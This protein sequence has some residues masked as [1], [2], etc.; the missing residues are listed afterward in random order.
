MQASTTVQTPL[1]PPV[2]YTVFT[3]QQK[4]FLVLLLSIANLASPLTATVYLPLFPLL[5]AHFRVSLQA[6]NLTV[7]LYIVFQA[8][9]PI[10]FAPAS[11]TLGRRPIIL[12]TFSL[13]TLASLGLVLNRHSYAGL[14]TIRA[15]QSL[16]ASTVQAVSYGII[17]DVC[18]PAERGKMQGPII[19]M[20]NLGVNLGPLLGGL[21]AFKSGDFK[22]AFWG[23]VA[24]GGSSLLV[25]GTFLKE[26]A[27]NVV[28]NGDQCPKGWGA[29]TWW[30]MITLKSKSPARRAPI[31]REKA[32]QDHSMR[33]P[34]E[35]PDYAKSWKRTI[36]KIQVGSPFRIVFYKDTAL[37]LW[38]AASA[39][40]N[41]Y[42]IQ[43]SNAPIYKDIYQFN[44][45]EIGL[46]Y[47]PGG[48]GVVLGAY[49]NGKLMDRNYAL[50]AKEIGHEIDHVTGDDLDIFPIERARVRSCWIL[51]GI[52]S[53]GWI[54]Y[55]WALEKSVHASV[56]LLLQLMHGFLCTCIL[57]TFNA[58]LVDVF[59]TKPS[60]AATS[61]NI[62]RCALSALYVALL[63]PLVK[64]IGRGW[65]FTVLGITS[66]LAGGLAI[67]LLRTKGHQW[68]K[69][70]GNLLSTSTVQDTPS[71]DTG[72][73]AT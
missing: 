46:A 7:T 12:T 37:T 57:Q 64:A 17:A 49:A 36:G 59:P 31:L 45:L 20:S 13:Y 15:L 24:F 55:G 19:S 27:R 42:C 22:W 10:L 54:G 14:I 33:G 4:R 38:M 66:G 60:A 67:F 53:C 52:S 39:Y 47:L 2:Q 25:L 32:N 69:Q 29:R 18:V 8:I 26:T 72:S 62:T 56:P 41:Y 16:G 61:G 6:I 58:L 35:R 21:L 11:D 71:S 1:P 3:R 30:D 65:Y 48:A 34:S 73:K 68:R 50:T 43:A 63:E 28:G 9:S 5:Q 23:L 70:R 51:I 44:E 40:A